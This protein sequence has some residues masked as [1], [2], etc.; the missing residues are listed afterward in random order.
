MNRIYNLFLERNPT[1]NGRV[2]LVGHSLGSA[3]CF[4][5]LCR[6]P[7]DGKMFV[8][9]EFN[10]DPRLALDF[11]VNAFF[12]IGSP[13]GLF[14]MLKGR[15]IAP[16]SV[17]EKKYVVNTPLGEEYKE[18]V[19]NGEV[20]VSCPKV[21]SFSNSA[22]SSVM[23]CIICSSFQ[24]LAKVDSTPTTQSHTEWRYSIWDLYL[25]KAADLKEDGRGQASPSPVHQGTS[26]LGW[27]D[28][29]ADYA[30][31]L[32][33]SVVWANASQVAH[34]ISGLAF[35]KCPWKHNLTGS[36]SITSS[37]ISRS[38]G[39]TDVS[40]ENP[41]P[42]QKDTHTPG[43]NVMPE[44]TLYSVFKQ[45][46]AGLRT[47]RQE[48]DKLKALNSTGR[49]DFVVQVPKFLNVLWPI[50][51]DYLRLRICPQ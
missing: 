19:N 18:L 32:L 9:K 27:I 8:P 45:S 46:T 47:A 13:I 36:S 29:R 40:S 51:R 23:I 1:F 41:H 38:L 34:Q 17:M 12:A 10:L 4:D 48:G 39:Y 50:R 16:R 25:I 35:G 26:L 20:P 11:D 21:P 30:N 15:N 14:Q 43:L 22:D 5:I 49:V 6:Q 33:V 2:S 28:V 44:E 42:L 24:R 31:N 7:L 37:L 3:I